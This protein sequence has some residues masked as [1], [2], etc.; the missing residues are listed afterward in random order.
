LLGR[1]IPAQRPSAELSGSELHLR[2]GSLHG[3]TIGSG[4]D[5]YP[6]PRG[7][8]KIGTATIERSEPLVSV[9]KLDSP[10]DERRAGM[11][12]VWTELAKPAIQ[13]TFRVAP[14]PPEET[15]SAIEGL[16]SR[17][18][19]RASS[20][21]IELELA[22]F[23]DPSV[24]AWTRVEAGDLLLFSKAER[25][26][27][28]S[29]LAPLARHSLSAG[30]S[31]SAS[32]TLGNDLWNL[33][34]AAHLVAVGIPGFTTGGLKD[35]SIE[36][37]LI[38]KDASTIGEAQCAPD[39]G[40]I[41]DPKL[42][43][44]ARHD[45]ALCVYVTSLAARTIQAAGFYIAVNGDVA[46][47]SDGTKAEGC[48]TTISQP[49]HSGSQLLAKMHISTT[50][51]KGREFPLGNEYL[52]LVA[53]EFSEGS[54]PEICHVEQSGIAAAAQRRAAL[55]GPASEFMELLQPGYGS[56]AAAARFPGEGQTGSLVRT[57]V[58][59]VMK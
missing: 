3:F 11:D 14:P 41:L 5:V 55:P 16:L 32:E 30:D 18:A 33:A 2:A 37:R 1:G 45:D 22:R 7:E 10:L 46:L 31:E 49:S 38:R 39:Q 19:A 59:D 13:L 25:A 17:A 6:E 36:P 26:A 52:V 28:D 15:N 12:R 40:T 44:P 48:W 8:A 42:A 43:V 47:V 53:F 35:L 29:R 23:N 24:D 34:R 56:R 20:A 54:P 9:A 4:I 27:D 51:D 58:L 50:T 57:Y 21:G